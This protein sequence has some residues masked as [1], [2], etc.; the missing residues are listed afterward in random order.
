MS[1]GKTRKNTEYSFFRDFRVF[2]WPVLERGT[3]LGMA[4]VIDR[5]SPA[6]LNQ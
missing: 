6:R 4:F 5:L 2:P 3:T 1:H